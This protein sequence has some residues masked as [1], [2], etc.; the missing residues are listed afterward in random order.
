MAQG[1]LLIQSLSL[2]SVVVMGVFAFRALAPYGAPIAM[3]GAT[4]GAAIAGNYT[5]LTCGQ[6]SILCMGLIIEQMMLL[7]RGKPLAAGACWALAMIKPQIALPFAL[8]FFSA[9]RLRGL[10]IGA[11]PLLALSLFACF[12]TGVSPGTLV[13]HWTEGMSMRFLEDGSGV[14]PGAIARSLGL[15]HRTAQV[16]LLAIL[17]MMAIPGVVYLRRRGRWADL[18]LASVC[19]VAGMFGFYHRHYDNIM[20]FPTLVASIQ[21]AAVSRRAT[22]V[23]AAA[24][25]LVSLLIHPRFLG[26]IPFHA[27]IRS[28]VWAAAAVTALWGSV[29]PACRARGHEPDAV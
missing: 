7:A 5:A 17:A 19:A 11:L 6:F 4:A 23:I 3:V 13:Q 22:A 20:L 9:G 12:W 16:A 15:P 8:L 2:A 10:V 24:A 14:G 27:E 1:R 21:A 29:R 28:A 26:G 18:P 25:M